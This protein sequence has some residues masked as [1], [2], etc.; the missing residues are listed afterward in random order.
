MLI[1]I[2]KSVKII[3]TND[4]REYLTKYQKKNNCS[5]VTID[6][7]RRILSSFFHGWKMRII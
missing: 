3:D 7:V 4:L 5:K 1:E 6:N 2:N